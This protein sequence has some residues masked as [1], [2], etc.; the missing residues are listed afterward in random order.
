MAQIIAHYEKTGHL[1]SPD[2][3]GESLSYLKGAA[4]CWILELEEKKSATASE[5]LKVAQ[6]IRLFELLQEFW[7]VRPFD[8]IPLPPIVRDYISQ[9]GTAGKRVGAV[10]GPSLDIGPQL[11]K[12]DP[13]LEER[14]RGAWQAVQ[15]ENPDKVS[16]AANSMVEV[17]DKVIGGICGE[18]EFKDILAERYPLQEKFVLAQRAT[19]SALKQ[20][21][22]AV[23]HETNAQS[24]HTVEDLMHA[25]EGIIRT[26][27]R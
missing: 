20:S 19:I 26:L 21:L 10:C 9:R 12:L 8:R 5:R 7:L 1:N 24:V 14:W 22:Q 25:A 17:L 23:K 11:R 27:M 6:S 18:R 16:Q 4:L 3:S 2:A 15:S 13:R